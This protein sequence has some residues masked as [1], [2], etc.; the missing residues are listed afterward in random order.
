VGQMG[1][2][3]VARPRAD[4]GTLLC[5]RGIFQNVHIILAG[6]LPRFV[7]A[8]RIWKIQKAKKTAAKRAAELPSAP[9]VSLPP[10]PQAAQPP[11]TAPQSRAYLPK[12][13]LLDGAVP[14]FASDVKS[15]GL[16]PEKPV[17]KDKTTVQL[18]LKRLK[19]QPT[20]R[21]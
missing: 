9:G 12:P 3:Y 14:I 10:P 18:K 4:R 15:F 1:R 17:I 11:S 13:L 7:A 21:D 8:T 20:P 2:S 6:D 19:F 16:S 5:G